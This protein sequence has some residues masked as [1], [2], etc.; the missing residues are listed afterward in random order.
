SHNP[1]SSDAKKA[2]PNSHLIDST[3]EINIS[4]LH[5]EIHS[6]GICG[7]TSTPKWLMEEVANYIHSYI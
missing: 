2:N 3:N 7:A 4:L 6:I 1:L 5:N